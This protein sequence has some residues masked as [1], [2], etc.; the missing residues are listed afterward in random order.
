ME[1]SDIQETKEGKVEITFCT[2]DLDDVMTIIIS[3]NDAWQ[4]VDFCKDNLS[5]SAIK[6][7]K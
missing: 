6:K 2:E 4:I 1:I 7:N 3:K 5:L